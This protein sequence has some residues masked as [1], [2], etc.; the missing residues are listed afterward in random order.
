MTPMEKMC[1]DMATFGA[2]AMHHIFT[3]YPTVEFMIP[4]NSGGKQE[5]LTCLVSNLEC[6]HFDA[7]FFYRRSDFE[8]ARDTIAY[9]HCSNDII[10]QMAEFAPQKHLRREHREDILQVVEN[11]LRRLNYKATDAPAPASA[12]F[13][14]IPANS[15]FTES[16]AALCASMTQFNAEFRSELRNGILSLQFTLKLSAD[17]SAVCFVTQDKDNTFT[18]AILDEADVDKMMQEKCKKEPDCPTGKYAYH[19]NIA[20]INFHNASA[21]LVQKLFEAYCA[22]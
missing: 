13:S 2:V 19:S 7:V 3:R 21:A 15:I 8:H 12:V 20:G 5:Y 10:P 6:N 18:G 22:T 11:V 4:Y 16:A 14:S 9:R 1:T 17:K